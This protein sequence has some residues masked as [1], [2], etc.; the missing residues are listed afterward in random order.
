MT[1]R[2]T[3]PALRIVV[4]V[5]GARACTDQT[6][7]AALLVQVYVDGVLYAAVVED[8]VMQPLTGQLMAVLYRFYTPGV[9]HL[10]VYVRVN[11]TWGCSLG[12]CVVRATAQGGWGYRVDSTKLPAERSLQVCCSS[13]HSHIGSSCKLTALWP[14]PRHNRH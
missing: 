2:P 14:D 5:C 9:H 3:A 10:Y 8:L 11:S 12:L 1:D 13:S 7:V 4:Y 6:W